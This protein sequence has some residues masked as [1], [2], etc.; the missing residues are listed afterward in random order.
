MADPSKGYVSDLG[1][2]NDLCDACDALMHMDRTR[3]RVT[4]ISRAS[5]TSD[6]RRATTAL[7]AR[8]LV[9]FGAV[10]NGS[11]ALLVGHAGRGGGTT[12]R[13]ARS[14]SS[15]DRQSGACVKN[16]LYLSVF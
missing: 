8:C 3:A 16:C 6:T 12:L 1:V 11:G 2:T 4:P 7:H 5:V 9:P 14:G 13:H 10:A 15:S